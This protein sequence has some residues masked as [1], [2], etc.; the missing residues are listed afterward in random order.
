MFRR[1]FVDVL[2]SFILLIL[3]PLTV[4]ATGST[5]TGLAYVIPLAVMPIL[6]FVALPIMI[7]LVV[8][9]IEGKKQESIALK[10]SPW[11]KCFILLIVVNIPIL[12]M[13]FIELIHMLDFLFFKSF[14]L[15]LPFYDELDEF[16]ASVLAF[17]LIVFILLIY[18]FIYFIRR[19]LFKKT[20]VSFFNTHFFAGFVVTAVFFSI[21]SMF[22]DVFFLR[23]L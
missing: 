14:H 13:I 4:S 10:S 19:Y 23:N 5:G 11:K 17:S 6:F 21:F 8:P 7:L 18:L 2:A 3:F 22:V 15:S 16:P 20:D 1:V 12:I 9:F